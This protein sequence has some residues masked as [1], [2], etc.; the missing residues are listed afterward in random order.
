MRRYLSNADYS[1]LKDGFVIGYT[2]RENLEDMSGLVNSPIT[3]GIELI[4]PNLKKSSWFD[5]L[6]GY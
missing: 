4:E 5:K 3:C 1:T 6:F 2:P